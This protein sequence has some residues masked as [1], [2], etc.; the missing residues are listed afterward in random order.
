MAGADAVGGDVCV[1]IKGWG[2]G[3]AACVRNIGGA[4]GAPDV[5]CAVVNPVTD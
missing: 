4:A 5:V 1:G 3:G 2:G